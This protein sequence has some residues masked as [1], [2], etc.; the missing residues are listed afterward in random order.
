MAPA[1]RKQPVKAKRA[2]AYRRPANNAG[3]RGAY[4]IQ[5]GAHVKGSLGP[6]K[7]GASLNAGYAK[8]MKLGGYG[9]YSLENVKHNSLIRPDP[10]QIMNSYY[11]E[12]AFVIRHREYIGDIISSA[13]ANTFNIQSFP[14][15]PAQSSTFP[16]LASGI[17]PSFEEYRLNGCVFEFKSTCSD[18][19]ASSTNLA[20]GQVMMCVQYDPTD[21][22]FTTS[23]QLLNYFWAQS[24][25]VS[26]NIYHFV[27]CDKQ[28]SPLVNLYTRPGAA[29]SDSDLRFSDFG[30]FSVATN[31]LQ[32]TSINLGQLWV[33][34]EFLMY[35]PKVA[36]LEAVAG[37][38]FHYGDNT[39]TIS[40]TD[41]FGATPMTLG[42]F[43]SEN[44]L[45]IVLSENGSNGVITFPI[46]NQPSSFE[47]I[48]VWRGASTAS[49]TTPVIVGTDTSVHYIQHVDG[50]SVASVLLPSGTST[51]NSVSIQTWVSIPADGVA[52]YIDVSVGTLPTSPSVD[53]YISQI[54]Y[55]DPLIYG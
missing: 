9:A 15:N 51:S 11:R 21:P 23:N 55:L 31:G 54:P 28:Q 52:H 39:S 44:N 34:Y 20:L 40:N 43:D 26:D 36:S 38:W 12:G 8:D 10:P 42:I 32:G 18:A 24:G 7:G 25:K 49:V 30:R 19:I 46:M 53:V 4:Y 6:F 22:V 14:L 5:G 41:P 3:G 2:K 16:W 45:N 13:T 37:G 50:N 48:C 1:K 17:G 29:S 27:E 47:V 35:K 33:S